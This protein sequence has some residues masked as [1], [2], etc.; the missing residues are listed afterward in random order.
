M[1]CSLA[2]HILLITL[3]AFASKAQSDEA[4]KTTDL[5]QI[6]VI[7]E[8]WEGATNKDGTGL[9]FDLI[10][11]IYEPVGIKLVFKIAPYERAIYQVM[12]KTM[13]AWVASYEDEVE[14]AIYPKLHLDY[15]IVSALF[16]RDKFPEWQGLPSLTNKQLAWIRGY[17]YEQYL[18]VPSKWREINSR[19]SALAMLH[20]NRIDAFIDADAELTRVIEAEKLDLR[21]YRKEHLLHLKLFMGFSNT[22]RGRLLAEL[23]DERLHVLHKNGTLKLIWG[24]NDYSDYPFEEL[25][26]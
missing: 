5:R 16:K 2:I 18:K 24:K 21:T 19:A 11:T 15:D 7:T 3:F 4:T 23:W 12:N 13:D 9:Y 26:R 14:G 17:G 20:L 1:P 8:S 25:N 6:N 10:K 22:H